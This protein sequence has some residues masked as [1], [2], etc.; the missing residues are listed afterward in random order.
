MGVYCLHTRVGKL[1]VIG[2]IFVLSTGSFAQTSI[3]KG[4]ENPH[5]ESSFNVTLISK[6]D[7]LG[8]P[9]KESGKTEYEIADMNHDGYLD[10][11]SV[12]DHGSPYVNSDQHGIMVWLGDGGTSWNVTQLGDFG[13]GGCAIGDLNLDG[14]ND[15]AWGVHHNYATGDFGDAL[16]EAALGDGTGFSWIPWD[17]GLATNGEDWGMFATDLA[18]FDA[19]GDLD[20]LSQSFGCC[21]GIQVYENLR[22]GSWAH[23]WAYYGGGNVHYTIE[24]GDFNADGYADF[25]CSHYDANAF[26]GKGNFTFN[27]LDTNLPVGSIT[28]VDVGD[29][30]HDGADDIVLALD[31]GL[32]VRCYIFNTQTEE[33]ITYS[34]GLPATGNYYL[35]QCGDI[36]GDEHQDIVVYKDTVGTIYLGNGAGMWTQDATWTMPAP[37]YFSAMSVDGDVDFDGREDIVIQ[38]EE[39]GSPFDHNCLRLYSPW[40][41]PSDL[42]GYVKT[43]HGSETLFS[44]SVA[45]IRWMSSVPP[46]QGSANVTI[47]LSQHGI[48]GPWMTLADEY[49]NAGWYQWSV[50]GTP[51][52]TCR[53]KIVLSTATDS[54]TMMSDTDF[55]IMNTNHTLIAYA[56]G[57]Y[58]AE[59]QVDI[60]FNG[61]ASG[62]V[63]PYLWYWEFGDGNISTQQNPIHAYVDMG[64]YIVNLTVQDSETDI[65]TD[66]TSVTI[67]DIISPPSADFYYS[68]DHPTN[69]DTVSFIDTSSDADGFLSNW[70]WDF[71]DGNLSYQQHPFHQY[72]KNG[73]FTIC[74]TVEDNEGL[75]AMMCKQLIVYHVDEVVDVNQSV[76]DRGFP[77]RHTLDGDWGGAQS[78]T[79]SLNNLTRGEIYLRKFGSPEFNLSIE[80]RQ[81]S[82]QGVLYDTVTFAPDQI[83][84]S[85]VWLEAVFTDV[86]ITPGMS[87]VIVCP[88]APSGITTSFGYEW[89]YAIGNLYDGGAFW[90]TRNS[91]VL[92]RDLPTSYEFCFR[93]YGYS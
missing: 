21:N 80:L 86:P 40:L 56:G 78:F 88:P 66:T 6:S 79:A 75:S 38:A 54:Y 43:P 55:S 36:N 39:Y 91:G 26:F 59:P 33:W 67:E 87:Y 74:L 14:I 16:I 32:G 15:I 85:W 47:L 57:P 34:S 62:G 73:V 60:F 53:I 48:S 37:G 13:Y 50:Q 83:S 17:D 9:S 68:P 51:S 30:N 18:D 35:I 92:W 93:T 82:P 2:F 45:T 84:T 77:I 71:G 69:N 70:T 10:I 28:A 44:D 41:E 20:I 25:I 4:G 27:N 24:T 5:S 81:D 7:G 3:R 52:N 42:S 64:T 19:D 61:L 63:P 1:V 29:V 31:D 89:A 8:I 76:F 49:P 58:T 22:N 46:G 11:I 72:A 23:R 65:D 90:F 12:G